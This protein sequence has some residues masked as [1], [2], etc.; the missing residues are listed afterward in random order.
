VRGRGRSRGWG[1]RIDYDRAIA[2]DDARIAWA[3]RSLERGWYRR[4]IPYLHMEGSM[5]LLELWQLVL[6][7]REVATSADY[8]EQDVADLACQLDVDIWA[9]HPDLPS[10]QAAPLGWRR[11][12]AIV[13]ELKK[14]SEGG[15]YLI[16]DEAA[17]RR[18]LRRAKA[19]RARHL[20]NQEKYDRPRTP[21]TREAEPQLRRAT[22]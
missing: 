11:G 17:A 6:Y 21:T 15:L 10:E 9:M 18:E 22:A 5:E 7:C 1:F 4:E 13:L 3:Q 16:E 20:R 12:E 8:T 14:L 2:D 19:S